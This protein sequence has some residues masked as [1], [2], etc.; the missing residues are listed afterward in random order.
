MHRAEAKYRLLV[1]QLPA[2]TYIAE[3]GANGRW[4]YVSPQIEDL[5]GYTAEEWMASRNQWVEALHPDDRQ[6]VLTEEQRAIE[7]G[8]AF[9]AEYRLIT[10]GG[11]EVWVRDRG[12]SRVEIQVAH[13]NVEGQ[14]FWRAMGFGHLMDVLHKR[15]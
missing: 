7:S 15:L 5:M 3:L 2:V 14:A 10:K 13:G 9:E 12:V 8:T 6:Q 1:E 11:G 4:L